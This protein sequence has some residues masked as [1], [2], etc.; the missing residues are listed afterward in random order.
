[1]N[2]SQ[3]TPNLDRKTPPIPARSLLCMIA[4]TLAFAA[5]V[6]M[7]QQEPPGTP[8]R[9]YLIPGANRLPGANSQMEMRDQQ[10]KKSSFD[11]ANAERKR[12]I[13]DDSAR[14]LKLATELKTEVE[15]TSKDTLSLSVIHKA[16]D[17][18]KLAH[19]VQQKMKLTMGA[20]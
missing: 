1:M 2:R 16:E 7:A 14:L 8:D 18:E 20:S 3:Q 12:Q 9:P 6:S 11:A 15:K 10:S 19:S 5:L 4:G 17:I 13:S